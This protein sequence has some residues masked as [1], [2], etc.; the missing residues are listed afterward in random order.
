M[1]CPPAGDATDTTN[2]TSKRN[3]IV[4]I[5]GGGG[6]GAPRTGSPLA[7]HQHKQDFFHNNSKE[8]KS[9]QSNITFESAAAVCGTS[10]INNCMVERFYLL[11]GVVPCNRFCFFVN[12]RFATTVLSSLPI[13]LWIRT[14]QLQLHEC[15]EG[16]IVRCYSLV[17]GL[18]SVISIS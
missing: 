7:T 16:S 2:T 3:K 17:F 6:K 13:P 14:T 8:K 15:P 5:K 4:K 1:P 12:G 10:T 9:N 18:L 11:V